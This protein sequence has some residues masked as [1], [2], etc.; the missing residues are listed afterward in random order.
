MRQLPRWH[1]PHNGHR[2]HGGR[3]AACSSRV[4]TPLLR[5]VQAAD[6]TLFARGPAEFR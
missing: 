2:A 6:P 1:T 4:P 5:T 3:T